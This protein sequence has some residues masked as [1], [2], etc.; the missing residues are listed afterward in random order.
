MTKITKE[1]GN[2]IK[3]YRKKMCLTQS[4]LSEG[5][6]S[7]SYLSKIENGFVK[8]PDEI[9]NL[10][11]KKL[12]ID[13]VSEKSER[14]NKIC[15]I[16]FQN[17][18]EQNLEEMKKNFHQIN[19][20]HDLITDNNVLLLIDIHKLRYYILLKDKKKAHEQYQYL[21]SHSKNLSG[22][23]KY[24]WLKFRGYYFFYNLAYQKALESFQ[25]AKDYINDVCHSQLKEK[26]SLYYM[27]ALSASHTNQSFF[28]F[29]YA[30]KALKYYQKYYNL[31]KCAQC[32]ILLG[33]TYLRI[34]DIKNSLESYQSAQYIAE[35]T[36]DEE[37]LSISVQNI[38][39]LYS[40]INHSPKAL[41]YFLKSY[42]LRAN[43]PKP[44]HITPIASLMKEYYQIGDLRNAEKWMKTGLSLLSHIKTSH[45]YQH[46]FDVYKHLIKGD[47][48]ALEELI[49]NKIIPFLESKG[50]HHQKF[51][52]YKLLGEHYFSKRKYKL[53][54]MYFNFAMEVNI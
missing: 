4:E 19:S 49:L 13:P 26:G 41:E 39:N 42:E 18:F 54:A 35:K 7:N 37:L 24:Y 48:D 23:Q 2:R 47:N 28:T 29:K 50:L 15:N 43:K 45:I 34:N 31:K 14:M 30:N 46:E 27:I 1:I 20:H 16:W 44:H 21:K 51:S 10:L 38:G 8:P 40:K 25:E 33:I 11:C 52:Y 12:K 36:D 17:L 5:I 53:S 32:H 3:Y 6:I 22:N 9:I